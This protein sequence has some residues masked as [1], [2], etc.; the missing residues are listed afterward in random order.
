MTHPM[1]TTQM[2]MEDRIRH[3]AWQIVN[4]GDAERSEAT[5]TIVDAFADQ[6]AYKALEPREPRSIDTTLPP[7]YDGKV[8]R[9]SFMWECREL[10]HYRGVMK[11]TE[12]RTPMLGFVADELRRERDAHTETQQILREANETISKLRTDA[13]AFRALCAARPEK[14]QG[15]TEGPWFYCGFDDKASM[16]MGA[17]CAI[18]HGD[19]DFPFEDGGEKAIAITW[20]QSSPRVGVDTDDHDANGRLIAD[21]PL[22]PLAIAQV[23]KAR[24]AMAETDRLLRE[25]EFENGPT[26]RKLRETLSLLGTPT[27][28]QP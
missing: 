27:K 15:H 16:T 6:Q 26:H 20:H 13:D 7:S 4:G 21:A 14:Y 25:T 24:E 8:L 22:L 18:D 9:L 10:D 2:T 19:S 17:V 28:E 5:E 11:F 12:P 3:Y 23:A 1:T